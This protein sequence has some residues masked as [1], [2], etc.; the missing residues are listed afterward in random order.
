MEPGSL[1]PDRQRHYPFTMHTD[2]GTL[3]GNGVLIYNGQLNGS[4]TNPTLVGRIQIASTAQVT[5]TPPTSG[6]W[7]GISIFQ[8]RNNVGATMTLAGGSGTNISGLVYA[9]KAP[10]QAAG[11][12]NVVPGSAFIVGSLVT[13]GGTLSLPVPSVRRFPCWGRACVWWSK[14]ALAGHPLRCSPSVVSVDGVAVSDSTITLFLRTASKAADCPL[15]GRWSGRNAAA[16]MS[17]TPTTSPT[18]AGRPPST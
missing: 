5:L 2:T 17:V 16:A 18:R 4:T 3:T 14:L 11:G 7:Q 10:V 9:A 1:L 15:C 13:G 12:S 8:D 6:T